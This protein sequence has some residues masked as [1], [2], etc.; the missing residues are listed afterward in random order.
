MLALIALDSDRLSEM[1]DT[2]QRVRGRGRVT[3]GRKGVMSRAQLSP[4]STRLLSVASVPDKCFRLA[5]IARR[6][7]MGYNGRESGKPR[8]PSSTPSVGLLCKVADELKHV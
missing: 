5:D 4:P 6:T 2:D 1:I 7:G 8:Q 3:V